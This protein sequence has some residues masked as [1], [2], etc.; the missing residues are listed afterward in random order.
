MVGNP[1]RETEPDTLN[2]FANLGLAQ[3]EQVEESELLSTLQ[4]ERHLRGTT[5][6]AP[7]AEDVLEWELV[8]GR[9]R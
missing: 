5:S 7:L 3:D 9:S 8:I 2:L 4:T 6:A 1:A